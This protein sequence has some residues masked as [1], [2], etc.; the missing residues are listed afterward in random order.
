MSSAWASL[1]NTETYWSIIPHGTPACVCSAFWHAIAFATSSPSS[2]DPNINEWSFTGSSPWSRYGYLSGHT[3]PLP[4]PAAPGLVCIQ[5]RDGQM[6]SLQCNS[7][8]QL[9][10]Q[11]SQ[12]PS[13]TRGHSFPFCSDLTTGLLQHFFSHDEQ[14]Q[15]GK[16]NMIWQHSS[17][18][19]IICRKSKQVVE[20]CKDTPI[21][22]NVFCK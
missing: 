8:Q 16:G 20:K 3:R 22:N 19:S 9:D 1:P 18:S 13:S 7:L 10:I 14:L 15:I 11:L 21:C 2:V 12:L 4:Q 5:V 6:V 17:M